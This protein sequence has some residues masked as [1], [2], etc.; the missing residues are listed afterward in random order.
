M[1]KAL[2]I[3]C[4]SLFSLTA[5]AQVGRWFHHP[6]NCYID[7][8]GARCQAINHGFRTVY[9]EAEVSAITYRGFFLKGF[10][11]GW[12]QPRQSAYIYVQANNPYRDPIVNTRAQ[13]RCLF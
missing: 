1:K 2:T 12:V 5:Q 8:M 13:A 11:K 4:I 10:F 3:L 7:S 9:C 6:M